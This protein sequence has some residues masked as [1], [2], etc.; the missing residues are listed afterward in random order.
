MGVVFSPDGRR[1]ATA[2]ANDWPDRDPNHQ[3]WDA[4]VWDATSG[5]RLALVRHD[6]EVLGLAFNP[7]ERRLAT[8]SRDKTARI[9]D[10]SSGQELVTV[11][12]GGEV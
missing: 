7:D 12:H 1:L 8:A 10:A 5:Q 9:W 3:V 6:H 11:T 2:A 4:R